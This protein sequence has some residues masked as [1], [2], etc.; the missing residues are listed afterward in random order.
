MAARWR[1]D[2]RRVYLCAG[3]FRKRAWQESADGIMIASFAIRQ[4]KTGNSQPEHR[5]PRG[6]D[7]SIFARVKLLENVAMVS[8][9]EK[10]HY[11]IDR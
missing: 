10:P 6:E 4:L 5:F 9:H 3:G 8:G 7:R 11:K 2:R 1:L